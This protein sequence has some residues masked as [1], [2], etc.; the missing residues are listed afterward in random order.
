MTRTVRHG[1]GL[2]VTARSPALRGA[3]REP[4]PQLRRAPPAG[5]PRTARTPSSAG[6]AFVVVA[7]RA[8]Q[9]GRDQRPDPD[10]DQFSGESARAEQRSGRRGP[11]AQRGARADPEPAR[12][13]SSDP[14]FRGGDRRR[15][16]RL[17]GT[18][19]TSRNVNSPLDR[20]GA[21]SED[22]HSALV[23][24]K[25]TGR[26]PTQAANGLDSPGRGRGRRRSPSRA[27]DRAVRRRSVEQGDQRHFDAD[28]GRPSMLS[29]PITLLILF[30]PSAR[31]SR[32]AS[33]CCSRSPP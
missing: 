25:I 13:P 4:V 29:L 12:A 5:A 3:L 30:S 20:G 9:R 26:H 8:R 28:F 11:A 24:F 2:R 22:G 17:C 21:V 32:A 15:R 31:S 19:K 33:R 1:G 14:A 7:L 23:D 27:R 18:P 16:R 10:A 6:W